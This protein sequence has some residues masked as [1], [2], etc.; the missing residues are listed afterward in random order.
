MY[1]GIRTVQKIISHNLYR[2]VRFGG[3]SQRPKIILEDGGGISD[4]KRS[5]ADAASAS[6]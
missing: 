5:D 2:V 6:T 3:T 1:S 4:G